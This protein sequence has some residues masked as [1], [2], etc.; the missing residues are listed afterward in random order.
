MYQ[1]TGV[2][3]V[4]VEHQVRPA[5]ALDAP[6]RDQPWIARPGSNQ[7]HFARDDRIGA[8]HRSAL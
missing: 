5:Q 4:V 2:G 1:N 7:I 6:K 8:A 3:Q